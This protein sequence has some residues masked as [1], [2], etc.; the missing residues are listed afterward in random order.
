MTTE[1][2]TSLAA[3]KTTTVGSVVRAALV[4]TLTVGFAVILLAGLISGSNAA[5]GAGIGVT[6]VAIFFG[7]GAVVLGV[8]ARLAPAAS[9]L[10]ALL[11]YT[12]KVVL[13][14]LVFLALSRSGALD[15]TVDA[16]WLGGTVIVCTL[17][18]LACQI[19]F[20]MRTREPLYDLPAP[21]E[22]ASFR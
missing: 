13:M 9:L 20:S 11:T 15:G 1:R 21:A 2:A 8:V 4:M 6:M 18:W 7:F 3:Y 17:V 12:L 10:V 5:L 19:F 22:E 14:G 16:R